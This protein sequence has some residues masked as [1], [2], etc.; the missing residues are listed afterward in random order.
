MRKVLIFISGIFIVSSLHADVMDTTFRYWLVDKGYK[1]LYEYKYWNKVFKDTEVVYLYYKKENP[2]RVV[3]IESLVETGVIVSSAIELGT[4]SGF[5]YLIKNYKAINTA[6]TAPIKRL[7]S[8]E[9]N[10]VRSGQLMKYQN[11]R[12]VQRDYLFKRT[13]KNINL[14][15]NGQPPIGIDGE[16]IQLHHMKQQNRGVIVEILARDEHKK[17]YKKLHRYTDKSEINRNRFNA[18]RNS[19]WKERARTLS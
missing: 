8:Y 1:N 12:V 14:M 15:Q 7:T 10:L 3:A 19:Y 2:Y 4:A 9:T 6:S 5:S 11:V 13:T 16:P 18:F 17:E